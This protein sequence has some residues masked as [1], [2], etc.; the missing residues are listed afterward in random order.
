ML[1]PYRLNSAPPRRP[2]F[3]VM[4]KK[5]KLNLYSETNLRPSTAEEGA[6]DTARRQR[7]LIGSPQDVR[8]PSPSSPPAPRPRQLKCIGAAGSRRATSPGQASQARTTFQ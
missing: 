2:P 3:Q 4:T 8:G 1:S 5:R 7:G 6:S